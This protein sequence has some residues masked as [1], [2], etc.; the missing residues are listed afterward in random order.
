[1]SG[2]TTTSSPI[3]AN[4]SAEP[5][6]RRARGYRTLGS[7]SR[8]EKLLAYALLIGGSILFLI[9]FYFVVNASLKSEA[10]VMAGNFVSLPKSMADVQFS[11]YPRASRSRRWT[12]GRR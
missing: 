12:S 1:M 11:N 10:Q 5:R 4:E 7:I 2:F 9:P 6:D 3:R 8:T